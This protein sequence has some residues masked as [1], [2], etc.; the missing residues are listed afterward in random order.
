M[1]DETT[2]WRL[3]FFE[4]MALGFKDDCMVTSLYALADQ[5]ALVGSI[6]RFLTFQ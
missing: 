2:L 3:F 4:T 5:S 6:L 1:E